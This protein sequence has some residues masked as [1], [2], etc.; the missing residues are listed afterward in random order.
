MLQQSPNDGDAY[1]GIGEAALALGDFRTAR[2]DLEIAARL[3][4]SDTA[5]LGRLALADTALAIDPTQRG[6]GQH[7]RDARSRRLLS[8]ILDV[9]PRCPASGT[10]S[11]RALV[12][13]ARRLLAV[14]PSRHNDESHGDAM[15]SLSAALLP[16]RPDMCAP[17]TMAE[18]ALVLLQARL[19]GLG[20]PRNVVTP[21]GG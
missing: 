16:A 11:T 2:A 12:D 5:I 20:F 4:P 14:T 8:T 19:I 15:L 3:I 7:E 13:S 6:I 1:K 21:A 10:M 18:R 9:S 17:A